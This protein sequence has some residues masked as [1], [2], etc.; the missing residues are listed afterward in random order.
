MKEGIFV[1]SAVDIRYLNLLASKFPTIQKASTEIINLQA[2][3]ELPKGTE[4]FMSDLHGEADAFNHILNNCSGEISNKIKILFSDTLPANVVADL[5]TLVY[6]PKVKLA[7][8]K[9]KVPDLS[10][11]YKDTLLQLVALFRMCT[12]KYTRSKVRKLL[13]TDFAY[14]LEELLQG[15]NDSNKKEYY[16][17]IIQSIIDI[18]RADAFIIEICKVIKVLVIDHLHIIG[19]IFDRGPNPDIILD[20]LMKQHSI[21]IQWG[22]HDLV[23]LGA[24]SGSGACICNVLMNAMRYNT[25]DVIDEAYGINLLPLMMFAN[26][27]YDLD[28]RYYPI[29][30]DVKDYSLHNMVLLAKARKA[31]TVIMFKLEGQIIERRPEFNMANRNLL[32]K[33][34]YLKG[35][36]TLDGEK[37][38]LLDQVFPTVDI[39]DPNRLTEKEAQVVE[40]LIH[41]FRYSTKLRQHA[42]FLYSFGSMYKIFNSNLLFHGCIPMNNDGTFKEFIFENK[43][44]HGKDLLDYCDRIARLG[45][46]AKI[47]S[48]EKLYGE[49]FLWWLWCGNY[50]PTVG[51]EKIAT[52][53]RLLI[54][55][56]KTHEEKKDPYY[57]LYNSTDTAKKIFKEF[58]LENDIYAH[59]VNGHMPVESGENPL[60][61]GGKI[62]VIDGGFCKA[63]QS[64]TGIAGYTMFYNSWGIRLAAHK[65]FLGFESAIEN[66]QDIDTSSVV[67]DSASK[68]IRVADTDTGKELMKQI[69]E[70]KTLLDAYRS[71]LIKEKNI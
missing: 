16:T 2:I 48:E 19:D 10:I 50:A 36:I 58:N 52:F 17:K 51:R 53:E 63:Y 35:T 49:D 34:D 3:L 46:Y 8:M 40:R 55:D 30:A 31:I 45:Y 69:V 12:S 66:N 7:M 25:L 37:C 47:D 33:I 11:W 21:D 61:A 28:R 26:E 22:N 13:P 29:N 67:Y 44:Y 38:P 71:G 5:S 59:I 54:S 15:D 64:K 18:D 23:W 24:A 57:T 42:Q 70:L 65:P 56:A 6:Y 43:A 27:T 14:V 32:T 39:K 41:S 1:D 68:R 62:I 20:Q 60:K 4:Y 9:K